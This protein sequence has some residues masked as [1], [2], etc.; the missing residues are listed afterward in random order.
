MAPCV[1]AGLDATDKVKPP[2]ILMKARIDAAC[3]VN[4]SGFAVVDTEPIEDVFRIWWE[5]MFK[6]C[7]KIA[8]VAAGTC[9]LT[10]LSYLE[11]API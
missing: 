9:A 3:R 1:S 2:A 7:R 5:D 4:L 8:P 6:R 11:R 10:A